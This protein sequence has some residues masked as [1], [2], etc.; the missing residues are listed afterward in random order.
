M[1]ILMK[2]LVL[3]RPYEHFDVP[4]GRFDGNGPLNR[5]FLKLTSHLKWM[6][7]GCEWFQD[8][9]VKDCSSG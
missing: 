6:R 9:F 1:A 2:G 8:H 4:S 5:D 3:Q 7:G